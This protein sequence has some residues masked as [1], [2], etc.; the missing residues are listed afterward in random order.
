VARAKPSQT[1]PMDEPET[2]HFLMQM[3]IE[4]EV[5]EDELDNGSAAAAVDS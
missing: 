5:V 1:F 2:T 4:D 3:E